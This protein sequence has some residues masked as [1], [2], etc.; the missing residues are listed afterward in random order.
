MIRQQIDRSALTELTD[1][2]FGRGF[3]Y[4]APVI[5]IWLLDEL[6]NPDQLVIFANDVLRL[7]RGLEHL[8]ARRQRE[9]A[10]ALEKD[11]VLD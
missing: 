6:K 4:K 3:R 2:I 8:L 1:V 10:A 9:A 5:I 7:V 11:P